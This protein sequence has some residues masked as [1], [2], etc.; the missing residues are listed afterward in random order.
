MGHRIIVPTKKPTVIGGI[1]FT[2]YGSHAEDYS[3]LPYITFASAVGTQ[4][5]ELKQF[6]SRLEESIKELTKK[7]KK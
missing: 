4:P 5:E 2:N 6:F 1:A 7:I 3:H